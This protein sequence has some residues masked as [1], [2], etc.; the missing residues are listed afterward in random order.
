MGDT[1]SRL[2]GRD[3]EL[4]FIEEFLDR[5]RPEPV[6]ALAGDP[7]IG[8]SRLLRALHDAARARGHVAFSGRAAEFEGELPFG[9]FTDALDDWL[10]AQEQPR[11]AALAGALAQELASVFPA[12]EGLAAERQAS[13]PEERYR[14]YRAVRH[15]LG[16]LAADAPVVLILDDVHWAD[17]GSVE[18]LVHLLAH[19]PAG[20]VLLA[21][22][23]RPAQL[24]APLDGALAAAARDHHALRLD[25]APLSR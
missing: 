6:L 7:G 25:V 21:L 11:R 17:P 1:Q 13:S 5:T 8:K 18:L 23:F 24:P 4:A 14:A 2:V 9:A 15:L 19:P 3:S 16:A 22:A 12:F 20:R 10:V